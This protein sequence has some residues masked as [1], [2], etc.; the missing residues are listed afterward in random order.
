MMSTLA[1]RPVVL[2]YALHDKHAS[3]VQVCMERGVPAI[4]FSMAR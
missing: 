4:L 1:H 3:Q 2:S